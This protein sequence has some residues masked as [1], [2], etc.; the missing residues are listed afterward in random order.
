MWKRKRREKR[1][2]KN[3]NRHSQTADVAENCKAPPDKKAVTQAHV[4]LDLVK[5][6]DAVRHDVEE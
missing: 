1:E 2:N 3:E 5:E 6:V 4:L